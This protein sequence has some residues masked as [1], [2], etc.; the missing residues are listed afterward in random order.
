MGNPV[1]VGSM[2]INILMYAD[3]I[4]LLSKS[5]LDMQQNLDACHT[6]FSKWKLE[7]NT[8]KTKILIFNAR[9]DSEYKFHFGNEEITI[10]NEYKYLGVLINNKM[11]FKGTVSDLVTKAT[12]AYAAMYSSLNIYDGANP[13]TIIKVFDATIMPILMYCSEVW[14]TYIYK[15]SFDKIMK[16]IKNK[17]EKLHIRVCKNILG[18]KMYVSNISCT[19]EVGRFP[20]AIIAIV[21]SYRYYC[22]LT[23]MQ[24][25]TLL[26]QATTVHKLLYTSNMNS[27]VSF[28]KRTC[29]HAKFQ[30]DVSGQ[31]LKK[32]QISRNSRKLREHLKLA[33]GKLQIEL[34]K[35]N[36]KL[37]LFSHVKSNITM[38]NYIVKIR[39]VE[40]RK[41]FTKLRMSA[42]NFDIERGRKS[43]I[44]RHLRFCRACKSSSIGDEFHVLMECTNLYLQNMRT[45]CLSQLLKHIPQFQMLPMKE[46]FVYILSGADMTCC[47]ITLPFIWWCNSFFEE[48]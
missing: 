22:R 6:Y 34:I 9:K 38:A 27:I 12:K 8:K 5:R 30:D 23:G 41:A 33:Y 39:N 19:A 48:M 46:K 40:H 29:G 7:L 20:L 2:K 17:M 26:G 32:P 3:D 1:L 43:N 16:N 25:N 24:A 44:P 45:K 18:M 37:E 14:A 11:S 21:N 42:H 35:Q 28:M 4:L 36:K 15:G 13:K 47:K 10:V 31:S